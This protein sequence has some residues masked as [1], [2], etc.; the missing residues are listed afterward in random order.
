MPA[1]FILS[2]RRFFRRCRLGIFLQT[3]FIAPPLVRTCLEACCGS[4]SFVFPVSAIF[5]SSPQYAFFARHR[6]ASSYF[7]F[8]LRASPSTHRP[9][10][11][12]RPDRK[13][14]LMIDVVC[15]KNLLEVQKT[16]FFFALSLYEA[17][18]EDREENVCSKK[19]YPNK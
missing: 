18:A 5:S 14:L 15:R 11:T 9:K 19:W 8:S 3:R 6:A 7:F 1:C 16:N 2:I 4:P 13:T 17:N 12:C 10:F